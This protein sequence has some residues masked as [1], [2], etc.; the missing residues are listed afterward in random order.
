MED[1][2]LMK[3]ITFLSHTDSTNWP[4]DEDVLFK[5]YGWFNSEL[6]LVPDLI[7]ATYNYVRDAHQVNYQVKEFKDIDKTKPWFIYVYSNFQYRLNFSNG[8][9]DNK[10]LFQG[11]PDEIIHEL[12]YGNA[13]LILSCENEA[14]TTNYF[15]LFYKLYR[16][17]PVVPY[18]KIIHLTA[19]HNIHDTYKNYCD[20][21][22]IPDSEKIT[23]WYTHHGWLPWIKTYIDIY[24]KAESAGPRVKK[25]ISL[26][27]ATRSH[28]VTF[29]SLLAEYDLLKHGYVSLGI[30]DDTG[31][32]CKNNLLRYIENHLVEWYGWESNS[33]VYKDA[34]NGSKKLL[35]K[36]PL[37]VDTDDL[38]F[39]WVGYEVHP[40]SFAQR[41][42]FSVV[43]G[44]NCFKRDE[45]G[46]TVNE[47]EFKSILC[48]HPFLL[49]TRPHTLKQLRAIG[50]KTFGQW[51]DES[52]DDEEDDAQRLLKLIEEL[53]RLCNISNEDWD[54]MLEEMKSVTEH[55]F[56]WLVNH[57]EEMSFNCTDL[58]NILKYAV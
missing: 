12:A 36:L 7:F 1:E 15:N 3:A 37:T 48:K 35:E 10:Q 5:I 45:Q 56:D 42:Y 19:A 28:R 40:I 24:T 27:R 23:M 58:T 22:N 46:V 14:I 50:F 18:N 25:F 31:W 33:Q 11:F 30:Q 38:V 8:D 52:Y 51:F 20:T 49:V 47:K 26:N 6:G 53:K 29:V 9:A 39:N 13:H 44:T 32:P 55:N 2:L 57:R 54:K 17:N 34:V 16:N 43:T 21:Y 4:V 41:S